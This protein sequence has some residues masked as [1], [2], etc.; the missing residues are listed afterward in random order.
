M[1]VGHTNVQISPRYLVNRNARILVEPSPKH[2][3]YPCVSVVT[4]LIS[5]SSDNRRS[6]SSIRGFIPGLCI[7]SRSP[8]LRNGSLGF[9]APGPLG[10]F[11]AP[12]EN[13]SLARPPSLL[14][15]FAPQPP[16][17]VPPASLPQPLAVVKSPCAMP[18]TRAAVPAI[19]APATMMGQG[20][21]PPKRQGFRLQ[22]R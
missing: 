13:A 2:L 9:K 20:S 7:G 15:A 18:Y 17:T 3:I 19:A 10:N 21:P 4:V 6:L 8:N 14:P 11:F 1:F 22:S 5:S 16:A 12:K